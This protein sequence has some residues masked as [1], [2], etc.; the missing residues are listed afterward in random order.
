LILIKEF[1]FACGNNII[2]SP[3]SPSACDRL[4]LGES[5]GESSWREI[6]IKE[7]EKA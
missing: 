4:C 1:I 6:L 2:N 3:G 7:K 5:K